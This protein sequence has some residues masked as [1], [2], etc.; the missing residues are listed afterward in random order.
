MNMNT[1]KKHQSLITYVAFVLVFLLLVVFATAG[2]EAPYN[3]YSVQFGSI[4]IAWYATFIMTGIAFGA[5]MAYQEIRRFNVDT[6]VLWDGLLYTVPIAI[7]GTRL[8]YVLFNLDKMNTLW[9]VFAVWEGGLAIHGGVIATGLFLIWFTRRRKVSYFWVLDLVGPGFLIG[10]TLGRWGNFMNQELYGPA[11]SNLNW[12]PPF[13]SEQMKI[14]GTY[15]HPTFLYESIWNLIG[16]VIILIIRRTKWVKTGDLISAYLVWYG[17]GRIPIEILRLNSGVDEPLMFLGMP[18]AILISVAFIL[19]GLAIFFGRRK[20]AKSQMPYNNY[21]KKA[22]LFDLD[23]TLL[24]TKEI[25]FKNVLATFKEVKPEV[26]LTQAQLQS[27]LG[28]TLEQSFQVYGKNEKER[29]KLVATFRKHNEVNHQESVAIFPSVKETFET[30]K[31]HGYFV[32]IVSS[33]RHRF[34]KLDLEKSGLDVFVDA[35]IGSDDVDAHKP[36]PKPIIVALEKLGVSASAA[37]YVGDH[38]NDIK[39]A[40]AAGVVSIA[41][42]YAIDY[43]A[44]LKEQPDYIVDRIDRIIE[45]V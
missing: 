7:L 11:V 4:E 27:F 24:D 43:E 42:S 10:Q 13:I 6:N 35:I 22:V 16:L 1:F 39:A 44:V 3:R 19:G 34:I 26:K 21:N 45:F 32:G 28:P 15:Y 38:A 41:V 33:K 36:D 17:L 23:G 20:F 30:L 25:I 12:L 14:G 8:W 2:Q 37:Y 31:A 5:I 18:V 40:K 9:D 29:Q